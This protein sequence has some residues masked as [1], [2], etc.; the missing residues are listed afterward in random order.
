MSGILTPD[1]LHDLFQRYVKSG[2]AGHGEWLHTCTEVVDRYQALSN[3]DLRS[4]AVQNTIWR[5][6]LFASAGA[7]ENLSID[8]VLEDPEFLDAVSALRTRTWPTDA[9]ERAR[10]LQAHF[11]DMIRQLRGKLSGRTPISRLHRIFALLRP[12]DVHVCL[13]YESTHHV[14]RLVLGR[15]HVSRIASSVRVLDGFRRTFGPATTTH[16]IMVRSTFCWWLHEQFDALNEGRFPTLEP[17]STPVVPVPTPTTEDDEPPIQ[18]WSADRQY[19]WPTVVKGGV[20]TLRMPLREC[21]DGC[22]FDDLQAAVSSELGPSFAANRYLRTML[23]QLRRFD[24]LSEDGGRYT[25]TE[26]GHKLLEGASDI[27]VRALIE[28]VRA[29]ANLLRFVREQPRDN[30]ELRTFL[31]QFVP[32]DGGQRLW[33]LLL[34]WAQQVG[35]MDTNAA[36]QRAL[37]EA[38][39]AWT[40]LLPERLHSPEDYRGD[41]TEDSGTTTATVEAE[42][43]HPTYRELW[44]LFQTDPELQDYV[45]APEQ[46]RSLYAAWTFHPR[47]RFVIISGLSGTGKTQLLRHM[48]RLTCTHMGLDW[49]EHTAVVPVRPDWR[50]PTGL[51]GYYNAL[52]AEPTF[53]LEPA[54]EL[55]LQAVANPEVPYFLILDEMNLARVERYF[56]P[57]LSTMETG[58][59]L[60]LH[61]EAEPINGVPPAVAWPA[62]LRIGGTVNMDETTYP[63]SDKVLD[64]AFTLEFWSVDL[65]GFLDRRNGTTGHYTPAQSALLAIQA[66]LE[67]I[68]R[69]VGYR[70]AGEVLDWVDA[71]QQAD[72][73][74]EPGP[75]LDQAIYSKVLPRLR[76]SE[77]TAVVDALTALEGV[78]RAHGL[79]LCAGKV[80][81]MRSRLVDTGVTSFWS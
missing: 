27:L 49:K 12:E 57:F 4:V 7:A 25:T 5:E 53:Q 13:S 64:R 52:H 74:A 14:R 39:E 40:A 21:V 34:P 3:T 20:E 38:G 69:H 15:K 50:D 1:Q 77:S 81:S 18:L 23:S 19:G 76:G 58:D 36:G 17:T 75:I 28:R 70:T 55:V 24:L 32:G 9:S 41:P 6:R 33:T 8:A 45:F 30:A 73:T 11:D 62:N 56:A 66:Q 51:L 79:A 35:L 10:A 72:P 31:A 2:H 63:F 47:K 16:D 43:P 60:R 48:A 44:Q 78:C 29:F 54:L 42:K 65:R 67:P 22:S 61:A 71:C 46:V 68:R 26:A 80:A 59:D 37:T